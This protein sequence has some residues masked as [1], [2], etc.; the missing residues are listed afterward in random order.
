MEVKKMASI[1]Q[2]GVHQKGFQSEEICTEMPEVESQNCL[3][4]QVDY[5][6]LRK[7][8]YTLIYPF[9]P[10]LSILVLTHNERVPICSNLMVPGF[11]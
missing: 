9:Y 10:Y 2:D 6:A 1:V 8:A 3:F 7:I 5:L 11:T 4:Q